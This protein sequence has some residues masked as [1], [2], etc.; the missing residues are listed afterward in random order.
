MSVIPKFHLKEYS[1]LQLLR[2][3]TL[4]FPPLEISQMCIWKIVVAQICLNPFY[5]IY[6]PVRS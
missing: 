5:T 3:E 2:A 4:S 6:A 1:I